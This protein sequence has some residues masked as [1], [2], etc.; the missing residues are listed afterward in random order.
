[1][2]NKY[3]K[4]YKVIFAGD[5]TMALYEITYGGSIEHYNEEVNLD[6]ENE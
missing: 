5:A 6:E 2:I 3:S 1:M 4:D